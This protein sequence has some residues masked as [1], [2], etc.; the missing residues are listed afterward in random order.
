MRDHHADIIIFGAGIAGLWLHHRLI[1]AGYNALLLETSGI[2]GGQS[3][4][5]QGIIHSGLKYAF[6]GKINALAQSISAMPDRWRLALNDHDHSVKLD[7]TQI[8]ATSQLLLIPSGFMGGLIKLVT[9]K[10]LGNQVCPLHNDEWPESLKETG[11]KG[12]VI[13]MGEPVLNVPSLIK[14]LAEPHADAIRKIDMDQVKIIQDDKGAID[15]LIINDQKVSA[16]HYIFTAA[17]SNHRIATQ[18]S[19]DKGLKT[20]ARPLLMGIMRPA[21]FDLFAHL[22]GKSDKP[23]ATITTHYDENGTRLWYLGAAV[24]ERAKESPIEEMITATQKAFKAYLPEI[25]LTAVQWDAVPIDR[26][27]GTSDTEGWMPDTPTLHHAHNTIYAW[28]TK[29]TFAPMLADKVFDS[30]KLTSKTSKENDWGFL[31]SCPY[32]TCVWDQQ[33]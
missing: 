6:A 14:N 20:Q 5:S 29:L 17:G 12:Q 19:H 4:A 3:I 7:Q 9:Q 24:A 23:V 25:D 11:F 13:N 32:S 2:G 26:I 31:P 18:L 1:K 21:P 15:H 28:P 16:D 33:A 27:E 22:V 8:A 10:T 30:L